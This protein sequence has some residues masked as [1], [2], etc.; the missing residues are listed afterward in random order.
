ME[1]PFNSPSIDR[2]PEG[3]FQ[4]RIEKN[5]PASKYQGYVNPVNNDNR[6]YT[7]EDIGSFSTKEYADAEPA[8]MAQWGKIGI[9]TN[10]DLEYERLTN[11]GTVFVQGYTRSD[12]TK[13]KSYYR[14]V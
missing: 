6:I 3:V 10:S 2:D 1:K 11:T 9:P 13:V 14:A 12:G 4:I 7:R 5:V 8:I